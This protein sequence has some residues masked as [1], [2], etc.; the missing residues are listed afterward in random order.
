MKIYKDVTV[1]SRVDTIVDK[2]LC[3]LCGKDVSWCVENHWNNDEVTVEC[4]TGKSYPDSGWSETTSFDVCPDCFVKKV[5]PWFKEQG[6]S[7]RVEE[8]DW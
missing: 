5:V 3:D 1:P 7:P 2:T 8:R 6:A 4:K